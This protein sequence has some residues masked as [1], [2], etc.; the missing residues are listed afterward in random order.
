MPADNRY[1]VSLPSHVNR[2]VEI[3]LLGIS[4]GDCLFSLD[5]TYDSHEDAFYGLT[6]AT[7]TTKS[8]QEDDRILEIDTEGFLVVNS[9]KIT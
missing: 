3:P 6:Q 9:E 5:I 4:N 1:D 2:D 7:A 8:G